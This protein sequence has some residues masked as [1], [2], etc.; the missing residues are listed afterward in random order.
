MD[1]ESTQPNG[2]EWVVDI[3]T[4]ADVEPIEKR[5]Y[6]KIPGGI[7]VDEVLQ[8]AAEM[9]DAKGLDWFWKAAAMAD[10]IGVQRKLFTRCRYCGTDS[11]D[12]KGEWGIACRDCK[13]ELTEKLR[14]TKERLM[15]TRYEY[16]TGKWI[17][18][19]TRHWH[20]YD[21]NRQGN[22]KPRLDYDYVNPY[23]P[24]TEEEKRRN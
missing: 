15:A 9:A 4:L 3:V 10:A 17:G 16:R 20:E 13:D 5:S 8:A 6:R 19:L 22:K 18:G 2:K 11:E 7:S 24:V 23:I 14:P 12:D 21:W 1:A